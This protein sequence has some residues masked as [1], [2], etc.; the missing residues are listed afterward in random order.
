MLYVGVDVHKATSHITIIDG[1]GKVLQRTQVPTSLDGLHDALD[2]Y[3]EPMKAVLEAQPRL[4]T[5]V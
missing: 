4:G 2:A 5:D 3:D 1:A